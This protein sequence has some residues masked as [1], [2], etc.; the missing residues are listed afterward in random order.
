VQTDIDSLTSMCSI[1]E[2]SGVQ[3]K[4]VFYKKNRSGQKLPDLSP[5]KKL[6]R[7][8]MFFVLVMPK[9]NSGLAENRKP[10]YT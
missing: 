8:R 4:K 10:K 9:I 1:K 2:N 5:H 7:I 3:M 6:Q